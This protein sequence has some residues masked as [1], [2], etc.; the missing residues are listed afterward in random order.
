MKIVDPEI[1]DSFGAVLNVTRKIR[2]VEYRS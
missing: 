2:F 1:K